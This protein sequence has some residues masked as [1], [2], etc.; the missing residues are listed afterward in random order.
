MAHQSF[1]GALVHQQNSLLK[2]DLFK[3]ELLDKAKTFGLE[4][5]EA[6]VFYSSRNM[7]KRTNN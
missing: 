5:R 6:I 4:N 3:M 2:F 7:M 1:V